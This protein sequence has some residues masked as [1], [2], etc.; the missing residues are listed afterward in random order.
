MGF[1]YD[2]AVRYDPESTTGIELTKKVL[3]SI[4][5]RRMMYKKP[6]ILFFAG[7]S[8]EGKSHS[9]VR[10]QQLLLE[11]WGLD[12]REFINDINV[13][14]PLEYPQKLNNILYDKRLK[15]VKIICIHEAREIIR[16]KDWHSFLATSIGDV[17]AMSRAIKRLCIMIY[18]RN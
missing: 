11:L 4:I 14:T 13:F 12:I 1:W 9:A 10:I 8:G 2:F 5:V 18:K 15:K 3:F 17:N 16:A 6:S 7:K